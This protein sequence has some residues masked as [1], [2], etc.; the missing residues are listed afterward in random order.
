MISLYLSLSFSLS[1]LS[2][3]LHNLGTDCFPTFLEQNK[4]K[5]DV[6]R[7]MFVVITRTIF[8]RQV[9]VINTNTIATDIFLQKINFLIVSIYILVM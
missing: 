8:D 6:T 7:R 4:K 9:L 1:L 5:L 3:F 2:N